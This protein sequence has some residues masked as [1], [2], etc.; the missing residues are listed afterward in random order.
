MTR[1]K[2]GRNRRQTVANYPRVTIGVPVYNGENYLVES[3]QSL[4]R[5]TFADFEIVISDNAS[6]DRTQ[7]ICKRYVNKDARIRYS[8]NSTNLGSARNFNRV[9]ELASGEYFKWAP[10]D[11]LHSADYLQKCVDILDTNPDVVLVYT[12]TQI[13][14][15]RGMVIRSH[16]DK[17]RCD[18]EEVHTRFHDLLVNY[19]C[20]EIFGLMRL[21]QLLNTGL[22]GSYGHADGVLLARMGLFGR[23]YEIPEP[24][25]FNRIHESKSSLAYTSYREYT[26]WIDP[27]NAGKVL[28]PRWRMGYEFARSIGLAKL[29]FID[30]MKCYAQIGYWV[31][32]FWKSL[33]ANIV[34]A[35]MEILTKLFRRLQAKVWKTNHKDNFAIENGEKK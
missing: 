35:F 16:Q 24:L 34:V 8:R 4:L 27:R 17:L 15:E 31:R 33:I 9:V 2:Y 12:R 13:I 5:Q 29:S 30:R 14:D 22:V 1:I 26:V 18:S 32:T 20:Y 7:E 19:M 6:T 28:L 23:F 3:L 25:Y 11:D 21:K 10:H